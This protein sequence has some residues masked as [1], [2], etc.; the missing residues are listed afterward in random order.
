MIIDVFHKLQVFEKNHLTICRKRAI[1][2]KL[3]HEERRA[4]EKPQGQA[5]PKR[6]NNFFEKR[7]DKREEMWYNKKAVAGEGGR[8]CI[9]KSEQYQARKGKKKNWN[10]C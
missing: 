7:L 4:A 2:I 5:E 1:I 9:L 8:D 3:S 6:K 10:P